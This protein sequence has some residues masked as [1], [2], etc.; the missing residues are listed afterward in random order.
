VI[1]KGVAALSEVKRAMKLGLIVV[2]RG[3]TNAFVAEE[4]TGE[5]IENKSHYAARSIAGGQRG[6]VG[7]FQLRIWRRRNIG[8]SF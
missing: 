6:R 1:A 2:G 8:G 3:T 5:K 7:E 4:L